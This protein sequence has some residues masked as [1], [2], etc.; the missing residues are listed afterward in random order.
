MGLMIVIDATCTPIAG[1]I[2]DRWG[3]H[4][5]VAATAMAFLAAG[6][7][8]VGLS[9]R[10]AG[11][12][13][14]IALVGVGG[15]GLGPSLLVVMGGIVPSE[16]RGTG[17][18][19]LQFCGDVGGMLGPLVGTALLGGHTALPYLGTAGLVVCFMPLALWLAS[20]ETARRS[21]SATPTA[22]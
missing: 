2:G 22:A 17:V 4:A 14:G 11:L 13:V 6:L 1:R 10:A 16:R 5:R 8:V 18:G 3:A 19:L 21:A 15:A 9:S 12:A 20:V 7:V